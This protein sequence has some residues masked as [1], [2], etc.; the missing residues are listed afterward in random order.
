MSRPVLLSA[1]CLCSQLQ[2]R[3]LASVSLRPDCPLVGFRALS[4]ACISVSMCA[5]A[6]V[7]TEKKTYSGKVGG[8]NDDIIIAMCAATP[9]RRPYA[10]L[11][12]NACHTPSHQV[13]FRVVRRRQ[14][15]ITGCRRGTAA[16]LQTSRVCASQRIGAPQVLPPEREVPQLPRLL[17][18]R[19]G[20]HAR[21]T[22]WAAPCSHSLRCSRQR[23]V[24]QNDG[25]DGRLACEPA[26]TQGLCVCHA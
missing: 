14:L 15:A 2:R 1:A 9:T 4:F 16:R 8:R 13:A 19:T 5:T 11:S 20:R 22:R 24:S 26:A 18:S 12:A 6:R 3:P 10:R 25:L 17:S 21:A 23:V 7:C